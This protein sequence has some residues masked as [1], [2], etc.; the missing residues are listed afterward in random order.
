MLC[1][2]TL[3]LDQTCQGFVYVVVK[4]W[5]FVLFI[6][7]TNFS[8]FITFCLISWLFSFTS[9]GLLYYLSYSLSTS[10]VYFQSFLLHCFSYPPLLSISVLSGTD[11]LL[12]Q[13][14]HIEVSLKSAELRMDRTCTAGDHGFAVTLGGFT[15]EWWQPR[16]NRNWWYSLSTWIFPSLKSTLD[17]LIT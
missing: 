5:I 10:L 12:I 17:S 6:N 16:W 11:P 4:Q 8:Y 2:F 3:V 1:V 15:W 13:S 14:R 7:P 9:L